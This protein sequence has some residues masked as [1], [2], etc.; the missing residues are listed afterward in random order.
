MPDTLY[1]ERKPL[2]WA[3]QFDLAHPGVPES[4]LLSWFTS[5][6][7]TGYDWGVTVKE[8]LFV[9]NP[10]RKPYIG[11]IVHYRSFGTPGGEHQPK[12]RPA[13]V[14]EVYNKDSLA[15][16]VFNPTGLYF[17]NCSNDEVNRAGGTWHYAH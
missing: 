13:I 11:E 8:E 15:L 3:Q 10:S 9:S 14:V 1:G 12:C 16:T 4:E 5:A 7:M 6:I 2:V 17:N